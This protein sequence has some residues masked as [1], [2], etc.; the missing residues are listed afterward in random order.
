[1]SEIE[2]SGYHGD[3][4]FFE[5]MLVKITDRVQSSSHTKEQICEELEQVK[6]SLNESKEYYEN[7]VK[8]L[9]K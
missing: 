7:Y 6:K 8:N 3:S 4:N 2:M 1:M 5:R 9:R